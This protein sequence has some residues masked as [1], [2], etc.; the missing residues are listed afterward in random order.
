MG[1]RSRPSHG[2]VDSVSPALSEI[3]G[4]SPEEILGQPIS[5]LFEKDLSDQIALLRARQ[6][7]GDMYSDEVACKSSDSTV[8]CQVCIIA[9]NG[10][11]DQVTDFVV[12]IRDITKDHEARIAAE[13]AKHESE[14]LL[15]A[16]M[17]RSIVARLDAGQPMALLSWR[18]RQ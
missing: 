12:V 6:S 9:L 7:S 18:T 17:P 1:S 11:N 2:T 15:F 10:T 13:K 8:L 16:I 3:L 5:T 14:Q 4:L